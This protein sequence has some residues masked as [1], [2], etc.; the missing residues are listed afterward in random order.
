MTTGRGPGRP[1]GPRAGF[2]SPEVTH[3][4]P[5]DLNH[6]GEEQPVRTYALGL[7]T[8]TKL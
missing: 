7:C 4:G 8:R 1:D 2:R 6:P 3:S 5:E